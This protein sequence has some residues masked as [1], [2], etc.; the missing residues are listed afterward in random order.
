M[1]CGNRKQQR[2]LGIATH[3]KLLQRISENDELLQRILMHYQKHKTE[4]I[5]RLL[6]KDLDP[7]RLHEPRSIR[8]AIS[9]VLKQNMPEAQ[10][11]ELKKKHR[12]A[13]AKKRGCLIPIEKRR[14]GSRHSHALGARPGRSKEELDAVRPGT[15][16]ILR[17]TRVFLE[18][19]FTNPHCHRM[20]GH[21]WSHVAKLMRKYSDRRTFTADQC[22]AK[23]HS[24]LRM[25]EVFRG[26]KR[27]NR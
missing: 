23:W 19:I 10:Y 17:E 20:N 2:A 21:D 27:K 6:R 22:R 4:E 8:A 9:V 24:L 13:A 5:A 7:Q 11:E 26:R 15:S 3:E 1:D 12:S 16:W 25:Q 14:E 18:Q